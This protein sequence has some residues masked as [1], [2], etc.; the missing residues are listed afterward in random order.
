ME[1]KG[2]RELFREVIDQG[3][4]TRCGACINGC[5][6]MTTYEG[7]IVLLDSCTI[8]AGQCYT[9]CP[10]TYTDMDAVSKKIFGVPF[11]PDET[12]VT[13]DI[14]MTRSRDKEIGS[15]GQDGGTVTTLLTLALE[16]EI[17]EAVVSTR[18]DEN[19]LPGGFVARSRKELLQCAGVSY[20]AGYA[21]GAYN[22]IPKESNEKIGI[23]GL[24]CQVE[25]M[26]KMK[27][28]QPENRVNIGNVK[29]TLGLFCGW[30]LVPDTFHRFLK[31]NYNL[32]EIIKF[33]IPHHPFDTF[34]MHTQTGKKS[35]PLDEIRKYINP[36]CQYCWDMTAEFG[37][38]SIGAAGSAFPGWNTVIVR[39]EMGAKLM[40][41]AKSKGLLE[42]QPLPDKRLSHLKASALKRKKTAF[43]NIVERTGDKEDLL[44]IG[45]LSKGLVEQLLEN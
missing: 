16:E 6:L 31:E 15:K 28:S 37:D 24:G 14:C 36:A 3:L 42:I 22:N 27:T 7:R 13:L 32:S 34:D 30:A 40:E 12:G 18:M 25:A 38:I 11:G 1:K 43:K 39:T 35:I 9:F 4:C 20:S 21:V 19:K 5:S 17:V 10:R 2:P 45:G 23:V 33:N 26:A 41:L 8:T 44:Y 29:L